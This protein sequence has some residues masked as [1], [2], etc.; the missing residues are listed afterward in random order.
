MRED[1][2]TASATECVTKK[3]VKGARL[4]IASRSSLSRSRVISSSAPKGSSSSRISGATLS[5]RAIETRILI[6]PESCQGY[7]S[8]APE[9]PTTSSI[10]AT[11]SWRCAGASPRRSKGSSTFSVTRRHG[12]R[13]ASWNT[14][15][16]RWRAC[17]GVSP[18]TVIEPSLAGESPAIRR[19][20]VDFPQ[21]LGPMKLTNSPRTTSRSMPSSTSGPEP[22]RFLNPLTLTIGPA[23][24]RRSPMRPGTRR[25]KFEPVVWVRLHLAWVQ[26]AGRVDFRL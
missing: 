15:N 5:A 19:R 7:F 25:G 11:H 17:S 2:N 8:A 6:P 26:Q 13:L 10:R 9:R 4:R 18:S 21:P 16:I 3:P 1:R 12:M 20:R 14:K 24:I 23:F 22:N